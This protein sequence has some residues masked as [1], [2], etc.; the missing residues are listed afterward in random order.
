ME[1]L[2]LFWSRIVIPRMIR[3]CEEAHLWPELIFLY[4]HYDE[5]DNAA[6]AMM[7]RAADA[8][9]HHSF[10]E[11]I[12]KTA[13]L[14][15]YYRALNHYLQEQPLLLTDLLQA[16]TPRIDVNRV[17][18][19]FEKSDNTPII[20]PFLL[21]VQGQNKRVVNNAIHNLL[22]EEEDYKTLKDSVENYDNYDAVELAQRLEKHEL[23]F[24]RQIAAQIYRK[25][26]RWEKS[27]AL[28]KQDKLFRDAIE[29]AAM[30]SKTE[31]VE[32]LL[33]YVSSSVSVKGGAA[34]LTV[35]Q[36]V[37]IG[38]RECYVGMLYACY[39]LIP[40]A[41]VMEISWRHGLNDFTMPFM[42]SY[43]S[44]QAATIEQLRKD[45]EERKTKEASQQQ[46][47]DNTP[48]IGG[49]L[50]LTQGPMTAQPTGYGHTNGITP[51]PTGF[52]RAF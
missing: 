18:R 32:D 27:I 40:L 46:T 4:C 25:N 37:D 21:N 24:F 52:P 31:V 39:D 13:N 48:I 22:I 5:W 6:L 42:I 23:V 12:V 34:V 16:L 14:E 30:S 19:M 28:S 9:E 49:R 7:E 1:H 35:R 43:M 45:N 2:K 8:W 38:S 11:V 51:Q 15:I 50:M 41:T 36:F 29:T 3:A 10:K 20:K 17:V 47:E 26:K 33:R 44:Q